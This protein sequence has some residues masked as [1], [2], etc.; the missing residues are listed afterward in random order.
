M[1]ENRPPDPVQNNVETFYRRPLLDRLTG[2]YTVSW[3]NGDSV[4]S[5]RRHNRLEDMEGYRPSASSLGRLG[6]TFRT[7]LESKRRSILKSPMPFLVYEAIEHLETLVQ[8]G[9]RVVEFGGGN[10]TLWFL[11]RGAE[12]FTVEH[13]KEWAHEIRAAAT[14][15]FGDHVPLELVVAE[16]DEAL[17]RVRACPD[18][19]FDIALVD[20]M[21]AFTWRRDAVEAALPKVQPGGTMCLDNSDHPNNWAAVTLLG[22][23]DRQRFTGYA[24][25]CPVVT[26]TSF[27]T[28]DGPS[29]LRDDAHRSAA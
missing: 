10:S 1:N 17:G 4:N 6:T 9:T 25:M 7:Y 24:P 3:K 11:E 12:V 5:I 19:S 21:N 16:S 13:S 28:V 23:D 2:R 18:A 29:E 22:R 15:R 26:Q 14:E 27:W 8:K 20:C